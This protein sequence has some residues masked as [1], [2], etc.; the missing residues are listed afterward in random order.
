MKYKVILADPPWQYDMNSGNGAAEKHY[1]TM[2]TDELCNLK[3]ADI[4]EDDSVL[5]MWA[6]WPK[7]SESC[8]PVM[9]AWGF[10]YVTGFPWIKIE[11]WPVV[12]LFGDLRAKPTFGTGFWIRGATEPIL[13][14]KRGSPK[15]P[16]FDWVG[17]I[18]ERMQHSRK[19]S[20][21]YEYA[22]SMPGPYLELFARRKREGWDA[23]GNEI[24]G[25]ITL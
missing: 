4:C 11:G 19:P 2:S 20:S 9:D 18:C 12:D 13:I 5:L 7:L 22:E 25:S 23:F 16:D 21:L 10:R 17:L 15:P 1:L 6:T 24:E 8:L 3:V 14:G